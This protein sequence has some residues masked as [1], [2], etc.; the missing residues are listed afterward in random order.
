M[1]PHTIRPIICGIFILRNRIGANKMINSTSANIITG[2]SNGR[3]RLISESR[4]M[5]KE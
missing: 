2:F 4:N 5:V 1:I 3:E